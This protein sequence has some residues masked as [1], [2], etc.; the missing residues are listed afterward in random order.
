MSALRTGR[1]LLLAAA[2]LLLGAC[3]N[4]S[5]EVYS[6][7]QAMREMTVQ[8]GVVDS[9]REVTLEGTRTGAGTLAGG[10]IGGIAGSTIGHGRGSV[11]GAIV[12][13]VAGGVAGHALEENVTRDKGQEI[14]V[15]L[16]NGRLISIVQGGT[17]R[18]RPGEQVRV[19]TGRGETRVSH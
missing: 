18:F 3:A 8:Y 11:V 4:T 12:G 5:S 9:V 16:D 6:R 1:T 14:T 15:K 10:A 19:L 2:S 13:A 7:N 17:E